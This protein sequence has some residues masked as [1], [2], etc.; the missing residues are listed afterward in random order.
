V[1]C[2]H[3]ADLLTQSLLKHKGRDAIV[4]WACRNIHNF[5]AHDSSSGSEAST[6]DRLSDGGVCES[7][8]AVTLAQ[9]WDSMSLLAAVWVLKAIGSL[10][11]YHGVN[12][13]RFSSAGVFPLLSKLH[14][15]F[16]LADKHFS[17]SICWAIGNLSYPDAE[18]QTLL[19][20]ANVEQNGG[21]DA[22]AIVI[23]SL[24]QHLQSTI[25]VQEGLRA[26][27]NLSHQHDANLQA[28]YAL[29]VV[30]SVV[31]VLDAYREVH[32]EVMQWVWYSVATLADHDGCLSDFGRLGICSAVVASLNR[33]N[34]KC[35]YVVFV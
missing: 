17:E 3:A 24:R 22:C 34:S 32:S 13:R 21:S 28:L 2:R 11:R 6:Q 27:R 9:H 12:K 33:C 19:G 20:D 10:A 25:V 14:V 1:C 8:V 30:D 35:D 26:A 5:I 4:V 23:A 29:G 16:T 31:A 18:N 15:R 7:L